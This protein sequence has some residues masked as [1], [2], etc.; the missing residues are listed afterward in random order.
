MAQASTPSRLRPDFHLSFTPLVGTPNQFYQTTPGSTPFLTPRHTSFATNYSPFRS[1][2]LKPPTPYGGSVQF[3]PRPK[4]K[5]S[6]TLNTYK[7]IR[8]APLFSGRLL[9]LLLVIIG[10]L[11]WWRAGLTSEL[12]LVRVGVS[13]FGLGNQLFE[14]EATKD[15]KFFPAANPKIHYIG[16]WT[17]T[18]NRLRIDG[19][20]PGVYFDL[21]V[22]NTTTVFLSLRNAFEDDHLSATTTAT[23][24]LRSNLPVS[25]P[26]HLSF[27]RSHLLD[28]PAPPVS[29]LARVD[30]EEYVLLPNSSLLVSV[31]GG[32]L[33]SQVQ[34]Q[35]RII[36]PMTD[37]H[38]HGVI[39]MEG[40]WLSK[41]GRLLRVDG[42][43]FDEDHEDEDTLHGESTRTGEKHRSGLDAI[44]HKEPSDELAGE[45]PEP[46]N[47]D[48]LPIAAY[49]KKVL[50]II[51]D[52]PGSLSGKNRG[53]R[54]GGADGLL[55]GVMGWEYLL[56]EMFGADHVTV[57]VDGMCLTQDC[58]GAIGIPSGMG[59]VFFRSGPP[60]SAYSDN[61]WMF[62]TYIPDVLILNLGTS[63]ATSFKNH[64]SE[65]DK[66]AWDLSRNFE[67]TYISLV[68]AIRQL[69]YP[70][71]PAVVY[72]ERTGASGA[73]APSTPAA[74]P[75]FIM[76]PLRGEL[77]HAT[78]GVVN[79]LRAEG[80]K[81]VFWID[82]SGWLAESPDDFES[83]DF[84]IDETV[85]PSVYRLT[86]QGNQRVA[87]FLHLHVCRYLARIEDQCAFLPPSIYQGKVFNPED[88][89]LDRYLE[90]DKEKKLKELFW[91]TPNTVEEWKKEQDFAVDIERL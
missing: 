39:Q 90:D 31:R 59:D 10:S 27:H 12:E 50:E 49:R 56:G 89:D 60:Q 19:T 82:T 84:H 77:E 55:A 45:A 61:P 8:L 48:I 54:R 75:I 30:Q 24:P 47:E 81:A 87:I 17:P 4:Q 43:L 25:N 2:G 46:G 32:D 33:D 58:I 66:S 65:Y 80:D 22:C 6:H 18:P 62:R 38:G 78:Q 67:D 41:G 42:S 29:L 69:A 64:E 74:I 71:H 16:R 51:T 15:L 26:G 83:E 53:K 91:S 76:R 37:G 79:R 57:G 86:E 85:A 21:H 11:W 35:I 3:I 7:C 5:Q 9:L 63:D 23:H 73:I 1:A 72:S 14:I 20:F 44:P 36:V 52:S 34:H 88:V 13:E 68:R 70:K 40:I 28:K